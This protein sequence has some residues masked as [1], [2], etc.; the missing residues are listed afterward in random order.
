MISKTD[1]NDMASISTFVKLVK[2][3]DSF[4]VA[5]VVICNVPRLAYKG[6]E[7]VIQDTC[8]ITISSM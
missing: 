6:N 5:T 7:K 4:S 2:I 3:Y 1:G 8:S